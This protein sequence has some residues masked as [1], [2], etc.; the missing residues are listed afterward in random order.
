MDKALPSDASSAVGATKAENVSELIVMCDANGLIRFASR[1]FARYFGTNV[2]DWLGRPFSPGG[3]M[4]GISAP[5]AYRTVAN[6]GDHEFVIDWEETLLASGETLYA[7]TPVSGGVDD[8]T[9]E[10]IN[11]DTDL[12]WL[13]T[14]S[15]EMRT[16]LNGILGM[17]G[18]LLDTSLEP[19]QRAYAESVRESGVALLALINDLLDFAKIDAGRLEL[20][21]APFSPYTLVQSIAELLSPRATDKGIEIAAYVDNKIPT[22]LFGDEARLR[23]VLINLAGNAV[24]FTETGGITIEAHLVEQGDRASIRIDVHDTGI[25]IPENVQSTI[26]QEFSQAK[27][28]HGRT[29]EGTGLGLAIARK[30]VRAMGGDIVVD[31]TVGRGSKFSFECAL[32]FEEAAGQENKPV[33]TPV[34]VAT[35]S[36]VLTRSLELQLEA[37]GVGVVVPADTVDAA[38]AAVA[39]NPGAILLCDIDLDGGGP[40]ALSG[41]AARS[42]VLLSPRARN[43]IPQLK[44][45]GFDGYFIKPIRQTSLR[46]QL[47]NGG[48]SRTA[49]QVGKP[50]KEQAPKTTADRPL[51]VLLAEDNKINAVLATTIIK[52]AGHQVDLA[53]NGQEAIDR[54][55]SEPYDVILMDMHMP[56]VDGIEAARQ[57]RNLDGAKAQTPIVALTA[58][59]MASDRQKCIGAGMDDFISKPFEP[60]DLTDMLAK[61]GGT[62]SEFS[63]AS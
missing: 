49:E 8:D 9:D 34:V 33:A 56:E 12:R 37:T 15:H 32:D 23:Q 26:F 3:G 18:L 7:G 47:S 53:N 62:K 38:R 57:I 52:R 40:D 10:P 48:Q 61:W 21:A 17:T 39:A 28:E 42:Y 22:K 29:G 36:P 59:A 20:N 19:N 6:V 31:S 63:A 5:A 13:A 46:E 30:I 16:P 35:S 41:V 58:N 14:M 50:V 11:A 25:G 51:R 1:A 27:A 24:K 54:V 4:A 44:D 43:H 45:K 55:K 2:E 60:T